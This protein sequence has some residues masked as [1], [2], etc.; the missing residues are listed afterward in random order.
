MLVEECSPEC[1]ES[2]HLALVSNIYRLGESWIELRKQNE[3]DWLVDL[4]HWLPLSNRASGCSGM[5]AVTPM[6]W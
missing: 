4:R 6:C 5:L 3:N 2:G 1:S